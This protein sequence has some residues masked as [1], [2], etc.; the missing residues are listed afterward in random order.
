M[1]YFVIAVAVLAFVGWMVWEFMHPMD[2]HDEAVEWRNRKKP[3]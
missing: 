2:E 3:D 1:K